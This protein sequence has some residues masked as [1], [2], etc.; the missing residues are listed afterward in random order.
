MAKQLS[1][2]LDFKLDASISDFTGPS[3]ALIIDAVRQIHAGLLQQ[4]YL[5][6]GQDTGK[7]HL[8]SAICESFR[9]SGK[10]VICLS[11]HDLL[12]IDPIILSSLENIEIIAIDDIDLIK[13]HIHWQKAIFHLINLSIEY[14]HILIFA[15]RQPV[16]ELDFEFM[17]LTSR[18]AKA[19]AFP[20]PSGNDKAD[21]EAVLHSVLLRRGWH[22]DKRITQHLLEEGPHRTGAM[23]VILEKIQPLFAN[24]GRVHVP[25]SII[26]QAIQMID[27][28]TLLYELQGLQTSEN[29]DNFLKL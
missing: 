3:W 14:G 24:L 16:N 5:Y 17:D 1:L 2:D 29:I 18:L 7:S 10:S 27:K 23:L 25:K 8:L 20:V 6:G 22:F 26:Q 13:G 15:S 4:V 9:D 28:Q 21:R 19:T 12:Q 11:V